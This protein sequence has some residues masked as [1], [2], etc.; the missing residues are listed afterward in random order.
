[1]A[2]ARDRQRHL[3]V[4]RA[5]CPWRLVPSDLPPWETIYRWFAVWRDAGLNCVTRNIANAAANA[6][7]RKLYRRAISCLST[8]YGLARLDSANPRF[9]EPTQ[10][11]PLQFSHHPIVGR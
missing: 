2:D 8:A 5:G 6:P 1:V 9:R 11:D 7:S 4:I 10:S 3:Y